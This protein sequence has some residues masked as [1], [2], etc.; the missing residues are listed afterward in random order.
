VT[1]RFLKEYSMLTKI[2]PIIYVHCDKLLIIGRAQSSMYNGKS[3]HIHCRYN[4][5]KYLLSN[6]IICI[7][8]VKSK[9]NIAYPLTIGLL[10]KLVYNLL[11]ENGLKP[12]NMK[13]CDDCNHT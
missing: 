7:D 1:L 5:V 6:E 2:I 9:K 3:R 10:R 11:R 4:N 8:Y 13:M 12:L